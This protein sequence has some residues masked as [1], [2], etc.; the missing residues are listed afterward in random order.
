[1]GGLSLGQCAQLGEKSVDN[2]GR[3]VDDGVRTRLIHRPDSSASSTPTADPQ[4][5]RTRGLAGRAPSTPSTAPTTTPG[6]LFQ[7]RTDRN[8]GVGSLLGTAVG[9]SD[10]PGMMGSH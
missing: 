2:W 1:M 3:N 9:L 6:P 7:E 8:R 10:R 5:P 4:S